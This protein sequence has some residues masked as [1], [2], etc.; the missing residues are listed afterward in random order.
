[1]PLN[2]YLR[3][4]PSNN[5]RLQE[6]LDFSTTHLLQF[7]LGNFVCRQVSKY[8]CKK[9]CCIQSL[10]YLCDVYIILSFLFRKTMFFLHKPYF[11]FSLMA[12]V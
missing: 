8:L 5:P 10:I 3:I 2:G 12:E 6:D 7:G 4:Y 1:M 11:D 9:N